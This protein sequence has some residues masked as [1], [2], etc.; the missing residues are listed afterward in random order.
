[1][2]EIDKV[3]ERKFE[4]LGKIEEMQKE[5]ELIDELKLDSMS[6]CQPEVDFTMFSPIRNE[7]FC[8][9]GYNLEEDYVVLWA[10]T[11]NPDYVEGE[12]VEMWDIPHT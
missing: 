3:S 5:I 4:L 8:V 10:Y 1:M 7:F 12:K 11:L 2:N 6:H 9:G